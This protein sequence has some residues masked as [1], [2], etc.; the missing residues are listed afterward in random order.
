MIVLTITRTSATS[1]RAGG[2][3][4]SSLTSCTPIGRGRAVEGFFG[5][6]GR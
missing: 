6:S 5:K 4:R 3:M 2:R 1:M